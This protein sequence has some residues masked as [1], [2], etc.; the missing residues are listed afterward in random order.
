M[1]NKLLIASASLNVLLAGLLLYSRLHGSTTIVSLEAPTGFRASLS[2]AKLRREL[3]LAHGVDITN[4]AVESELAHLAA[5]ENGFSLDVKELEARYYLATQDPEIRSK[6]D[7]GKLT[8]RELRQT[9][10]REVLLD[11]LTMS[12]LSKDELETALHEYYDHFQR[13]LEEIRVRH[14]LVTTQKE[15]QDVA[16]RLVAGVDFEP[17]AQ[18]FSLDP[19]T[20]EQGGDLGWKKRADLPEDLSP[21]LFLI[22]PGRVS[23]PISTDHGWDIFMVDEKRSD[24]DS[25]RDTVRREWCKRQRPDTLAQLKTVYKVQKPEDAA[26]PDSLVPL[27]DRWFLPS[28]PN[29]EQ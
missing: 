23:N 1:R 11:Q 12:R 26:L 8:E 18:R 10:E 22:P 25:L 19:L 28:D 13:D 7:R 5:R 15:A 2:A 21:L 16:E 17:L 3:A 29:K 9:I 6:L 24:F 27:E 4:N 14:I 20:R